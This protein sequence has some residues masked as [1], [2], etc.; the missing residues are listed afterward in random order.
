MWL[1]MFENNPYPD[2]T[3]A[4]FLLILN[5]IVYYGRFVPYLVMDYLPFFQRYK[6]QGSRPTPE[7]VFRVMKFVTISKLLVQFPMSI[8]FYGI[9]VFLGFAIREVPF[10]LLS[11]LAAQQLLFVLCE[12]TFHYW[13]H[14]LLHW[15]P[16]Y[17]NIHKVHHEFQ[18]PFGITA[19]YAH[20]LE[21][22]ILGIGFFVGPLLAAGVGVVYPELKLH[23]ISIVLWLPLRLILTVDEH[24]GYD[25]PWSIHHFVPVF[26][27]A[28]FHDYHHM[29]FIGNYGSTF[30]F[31]DWFCGTDSGYKKH[32]AKLR[33]LK[34]SQRKVGR[35][36]PTSLA[37]APENSAEGVLD[38]KAKQS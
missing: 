33:S 3:L 31:W 14:R 38:V 34:R 18:S 24:S 16:F 21:V 11:V 12:D 29:A 22:L 25:F 30:R 7:Q 5:D 2:V 27:G 10:P 35:N 36:N 4:A 28:E 23:M 20:T 26:A 9:S 8:G 32:A 13:V 17:K 19:V 6:I 37:A 15:G 1:R